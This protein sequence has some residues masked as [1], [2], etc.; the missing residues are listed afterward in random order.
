MK[1]NANLIFAKP[2]QICVVL[3]LYFTVE[4]VKVLVIGAEYELN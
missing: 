3:L 2:S 1:G 4:F